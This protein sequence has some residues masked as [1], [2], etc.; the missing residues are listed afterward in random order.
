MEFKLFYSTN[1]QRNRGERERERGGS[2]KAKHYTSNERLLQS[3]N[4]ILFIYTTTSQNTKID[5]FFALARW[6]NA[7]FHRALR[8]HKHTF[9]H[10]TWN[11]C[12]SSCWMCLFYKVIVEHL[13][14]FV[15]FRFNLCARF[16]F[17]IKCKK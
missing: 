17:S 9:S 8:T 1:K 7:P 4:Y 13:I 15:W 14:Q 2:A 3:L 5:H 16:F 12:C 6:K 11:I 10:S